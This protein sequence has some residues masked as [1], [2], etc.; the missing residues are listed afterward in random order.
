MKGLRFLLKRVNLRHL[1]RRKLRTSLT[2]SGIAAGVALVFAISIIN[3]TLLSSFR[4]SVRDLAGSA[5]LEVAAT[6]QSGLPERTIEEVSSVPGVDAAVPILRS[7]TEVT[8]G[9]T[10]RRIQILGITP[11]LPS[12]FPSDAFMSDLEMSGGFGSAGEGLLL[13]RKI[14]SELGVGEGETVVVTT[15]EGAR[16]LVLSGLVSGGP[17]SLLDGGNIGVMLLPAAQEVFGRSGRVDSIYVTGDP[18]VDLADVESALDEKLDGRAIVGPPGE[19]GQ[20]LERIFGGLG[21]LLSLAGT[22]ALFVALFVVYNTMSITLAE[23]RKEISMA[24]ALGATKKQ[25]SGGFVTEALLLGTISSAGGIAFGYFLA[26]FLS[27]RA[28]E[29]YRILPITGGGPL[30]V[31]P[32]RVLF[33]ALG[34]IGVS[35]LGAFVPVRRVLSV[36]PIEAL[37]PVASYE[38]DRSGVLGLGRRTSLIAGSGALAVSGALLTYYISNSEARSVITVGLVFGLAGV[39]LLLPHIVPFAVRVLRPFTTRLFGPSG[40]LAADSLARNPGRTTFTV[41][42]LVLTLGMVIGVGSA[43]GSYQAQIERTASALIGAPYYV[44]SSSFTGITSDQPLPARVG[45]QLAAT[46]G[47]RYVYPVR[48]VLLNVGREQGLMYAVPVTE[49]VEQGATTDLSEIASDGD[50]FLKGLS[51]GEI[52]VSQLTADRNS[53][54][55]G[56]ELE[57]PTPLGRRAFKVAA[58]FNDLVSFDS[59]YIDYETYR[60]IW[61]DDK[62]DEFG[63]LLDPGIGPAEAERA[64]SRTIEATGVD[65]QLQSKNQLIDRILEVVEGTFS[66]G[67][68]IQLAALV[69]AVLTILNTMFTAV[70]ERR[71]EMGLERALGMSGR[72]LRRSVLVEA[73]SIGIIG[74]VG[75]AILGTASGWLMTKAMEAQF[76]WQ[77][78]FQLPV[79]VGFAAIAGGMILAG[80]AGVLPSRTAVRTSIVESLRY[81]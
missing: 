81:E 48:F 39:T 22:V 16:A 79:M 27:E 69:V 51:R 2:I 4:A 71:W 58:V 37:R 57:L 59:L 72:Q 70:L 54:E 33:A 49:A 23:R 7:I 66:L 35:L 47:V 32:S 20:G 34:G 63:L 26:R 30:V 38:F 28:L 44:V 56:D 8:G 75:G 25:V 55:P 3:A 31:T 62:A 45:R 19:R 11:D 13:S 61:K 21:T 15:P 29:S 12:L 1:R 50:A 42:A 73:S 9:P 65:A 17:V 40:R 53:L 74:G 6:D 60:R 18:D 64:L 68:G 5:E 41:A 10:S 76:A 77:I 80:L 36:V 46:P 43:L 14:A 78:M 52:A 24:L 67:R